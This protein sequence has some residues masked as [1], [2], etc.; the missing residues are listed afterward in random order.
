MAGPL[1]YSLV[2]GM[3]CFLQTAAGHYQS[4]A[5]QYCFSGGFFVAAVHRLVLDKQGSL[6]RLAD[7]LCMKMMTFP[8][9]LH[10]PFY[11]WIM[12]LLQKTVS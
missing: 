7:I 1:L 6:Q 11:N 3:W 2:H 12:L 8:L 9:G 5:F 10:H 4:F